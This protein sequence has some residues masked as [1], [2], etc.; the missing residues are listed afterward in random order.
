MKKFAV[1]LVAIIVS[2]GPAQARTPSHSLS[3]AHFPA[4]SE[5]LVKELCVCRRGG[6]AFSRPQLCRA[7]W[8]CH[9]FDGVCRQ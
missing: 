1:L 4:C 8:Y 6:N 5:G 2:Y 3:H 7:G 9:T